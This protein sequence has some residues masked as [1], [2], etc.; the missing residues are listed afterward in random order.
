[1]VVQW[2]RLRASNARAKGSIPAFGEIRS[3]MLCGAAKKSKHNLKKIV[4]IF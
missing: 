3:H 1:M 2:L 4:K